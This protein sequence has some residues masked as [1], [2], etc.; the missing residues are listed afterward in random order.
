MFK[1]LATINY[2]FE[3]H[4]YVLPLNTDWFDKSIS[5]QKLRSQIFQ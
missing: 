1:H 4:T 5:L 2:S 3:N